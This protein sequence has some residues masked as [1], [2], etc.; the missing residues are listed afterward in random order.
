[1]SGFLTF[2]NWTVRI[3][4]GLFVALHLYA[5]ALIWLPIPGTVLMVQQ[6]GVISS[7]A[8][9]ALN[10]VFAVGREVRE[11]KLSGNKTTEE[12]A[13]AKFGDAIARL[14]VQFHRRSL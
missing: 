10:Y 11:A 13:V 5:L 7:E 1:M 4:A 14:H 6:D 9:E 8:A 2:L 12:E 3:L